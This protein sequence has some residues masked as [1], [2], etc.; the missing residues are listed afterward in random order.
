[1]KSEQAAIGLGVDVGGTF[2]D[3]FALDEKTG[4]IQITKVPST[5]ED[6]SIG[7]MNGVEK[8][9][10]MAGHNNQA[11]ASIVHGTTVGTNALLERKVARCGLI[12]THGF[13][14]VLEMRRRDRPATWGLRGSFEP[15]IER[16]LRLEVQER[17]LADG[18]IR[19]AVD[20]SAVIAAA[21]QLL[22]QG[23]ESLC[24]FFINSYANAQNERQAS[25]W[26]A[27]RWPDLAVTASHQ[28]LPEVR[29]FER[30]STA[31]LNAAL[32][33]VVG[34]YIG[35][36]EQALNNAT[37]NTT[38]QAL[39][40]IV[41]SNGGL[42]TVE[43]TRQ[44]PIRTALS[45]PAAGVIACAH[46]AATA[47]FDNVITGD[48]GGTSFD[49]SLIADGQIAQASQQSI[50]FG[51]VVRTP[52]VQIQTIG[53]G[54]GSV[55]HLDAS[56]LLQ[57][58]PESA[59]SDPGPVCYGRR[60]PQ[61][62]AGIGPTVTDANV[63]LGRINANKPIG[64]LRQLDTAAAGQAIE[65]TIAR[66]LNLSV[67]QAA[68]AILTVANAN[69]AGAMRLVSIERGHDPT[70]FAYMPFGGG[71]A[72]HVCAMLREVGVAHGLISR[73]PGVS[74]ALGCAIADMQ[75]DFVQTLNQPFARLDM[76]GLKSRMSAMIN[77]GQ[78]MLDDAGVPFQ[79]VKA[80]CELDMLYQGQT[81]TVVVP[82]TTQ[83]P[84]M[85]DSN[86]QQSIG[87]AFEQAY[88]RAFGQTLTGVPTRVMNLRVSVVGIREKFDLQ[89]LAPPSDQV[90]QVLPRE[91]RQVHHDQQWFDTPVF[92][93]LSLP[94]GSKIDGPAVFEQDDTTV[95]LEPGFQARTDSLGNLI[96][97]RLATG[98]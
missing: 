22:A 89:M 80:H 72:L 68:E 70:R 36:L 57:V 7:F 90:S 65:S 28:I 95:W 24:I 87:Q 32:Q 30:A 1:M 4:A 15:L 93:R 53:A 2:T 83:L 43:N 77:Q 47:G 62:H 21:E 41:Q 16:R 37:E 38:R 86:A 48:V 97:S 40:L 20:Q 9:L 26:I 29:E 61:Q 51:M 50:D 46:I 75:H 96:V 59:G 10:T 74:S 64:A 54:G 58:G 56:G 66:P 84:D 82:V 55:A 88:R 85:S 42:M 17:T 8:A 14:D 45:G 12:T 52:M 44:N 49:V 76:P 5:R 81:H 6:Q 27:Q 35:R 3:V 73:Y 11:L 25:Q 92:D 60:D 69:M 78:S 94:A 39:L 63:V 31:S 34:R 91:S 13:R 98:D 23:C 79:T 67:E 18:T 71:G 19:T 33:P